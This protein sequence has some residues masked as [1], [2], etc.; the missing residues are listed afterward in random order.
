MKRNKSA[1]SVV[2]FALVAA[3]IAFIGVIVIS[4]L[5]FKVSDKFKQSAPI[6]NNENPAGAAP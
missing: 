5:V 2:E 3:F 1:Q 6:Q 4:P